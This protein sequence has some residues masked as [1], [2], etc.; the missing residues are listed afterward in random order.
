MNVPLSAAQRAAGRLR[1]VD[2]RVWHDEGSKRKRTGR[3]P[4]IVDLT[5]VIRI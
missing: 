4:P 2:L 1:R 5:Q 3:L